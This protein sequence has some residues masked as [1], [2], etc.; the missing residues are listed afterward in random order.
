MRNQDG[1][2]GKELQKKV[3]R[4]VCV[5]TSLFSTA[6]PPFYVNLFKGYFM[7][8][9]FSTNNFLNYLFYIFMLNVLSS[10]DRFYPFSFYFCEYS[11]FV[12]S[13]F[14][15]IFCVDFLLAVILSELHEK[16][17]RNNRRGVTEK[18]T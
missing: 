13:V 12:Y 7:R 4:R 17:R 9:K 10:S 16:P 18:S 3:H 14:N 1:I 8:I 15:D 6:R 5:R 2:T 11:L